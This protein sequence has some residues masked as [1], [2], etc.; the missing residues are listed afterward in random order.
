MEKLYKKLIFMS[1]Y[2]KK[3]NGKSARSHP[4]LRKNASRLL[5]PTTTTALVT[6]SRSLVEALQGGG[7]ER[8]LVLLRERIWRLEAL[9]RRITLL[10]VP[11]HCG[12]DGN[13]EADRLAEEGGRMDQAAV[14]VEA[15]ARM[16]LIRRGMRQEPLRHERLREV[17]GGEL[18]ESEEAS[19]PRQDRVNLTRFRTG[20]HPSLGRWRAMVGR[21]E[22]PTCRL[23]QMGEESSEHLWMEC[24]ALEALRRR[25]QLGRSMTELVEH[26]LQAWA[27]LGE[28]LSRL[29]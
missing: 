17:Y 6:D 29:G 27:M 24:G 8:R 23:C 1:K 21:T 20:H 14:P 25:H 28:I 13:E 16:A 4:R 3:N 9:E 5:A 18:R 12:V 2:L 22:D 19:L 7:A 15:A 11:G 10:W 26:P